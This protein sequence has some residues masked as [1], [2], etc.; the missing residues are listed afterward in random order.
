M[1]KFNYNYLLLLLSP[2]FFAADCNKKGSTPPP[3]SPP[4]ALVLTS[5]KLDNTAALT[6]GSNYN[7]R[8]NVS[9]RL[10][11]NNALDKSSVSSSVSVTENGTVT[12]PLNYAYEN[13]DSTIVVT[14]QSFLK[15]LTRYSI[16]ASTSLQSIKKGKLNTDF[17]IQFI[18]QI[19]SSDKFPVIS[20]N[21]LLDL[22]QKPPFVRLIGGI[23]D[24]LRDV[25]AH[26]W[27]V[28]QWPCRI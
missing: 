7:V 25:R 6:T 16:T 8:T 1:I 2:V 10:S 26:G 18:T 13:N 23:A 4:A 22:V 27:A 21:A 20:D 9:I 5:A 15:N 12:V 28:F 3:P 17:S 24:D 11:F 19:D 14:S